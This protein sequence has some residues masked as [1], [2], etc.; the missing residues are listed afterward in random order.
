MR[1]RM[2]LAKEISPI[3]RPR[4]I[5]ESGLAVRS[6]GERF[7]KV[8]IKPGNKEKE[9]KENLNHKKNKRK[10]IQIILSVCLLLVK[11]PMKIL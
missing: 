4:G 6:L 8:P 1:T 3:P 5:R 10:D 9:L 11:Y 7:V 2:T